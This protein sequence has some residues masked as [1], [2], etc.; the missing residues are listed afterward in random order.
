VKTTLTLDV[1]KALW[2]HIKETSYAALEV[3]WGMFNGT[4]KD[5][6]IVDCV[7]YENNGTIRCYE[8]KTS[9]SDLKHGQKMTFVGDYNYLVTTQEVY[10]KIDYLGDGLWGVGIFVVNEHGYLKSVKRA[11]KRNMSLGD[12]TTMLESMV[13]ALSREANKLYMLESGLNE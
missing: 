11:R 10:D 4:G 7:S 3:P 1:E 5:Y 2:E 13:R 9:Y 12:K 6:E 8:I